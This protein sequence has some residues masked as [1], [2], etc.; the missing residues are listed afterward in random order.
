MS[1]NEKEE[2]FFDSGAWRQGPPAI[3]GG[4]WPMQSDPTEN[5]A[6]FDYVFS[7]EECSKIIELGESL[8]K[9]EATIKGNLINGEIRKS[10]ISW[11]F[12]NQNSGWIFHK[13]QQVVGFLNSNFFNFDLQYFGEGLQ[14]T[15]Y[16]EPD[17]HYIQHVDRFKGGQ[18]RKLSLSI[19]LNDSSEFDGGNLLLFNG[20]DPLKVPMKQG[21]MIA[22]PSYVL[23]E[24]T[25]VTR[26]TRY[27]LVAWVSGPPFR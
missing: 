15:K 17:G 26:G 4:A 1:D 24:V 23:H 10:T 5:C 7:S 16:T 18:I 21:K 20:V 14:F 25:P 27:S 19:Q 9:R 22:F 2:R 13:L 12:P 3:E 8:A 11:I 6:H